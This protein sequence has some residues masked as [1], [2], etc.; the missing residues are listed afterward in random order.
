MQISPQNLEHCCVTK[1]KSPESIERKGE[2]G[3]KGG[4][5]AK[6]SNICDVT[7]SG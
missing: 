7:P 6:I 4:N 3:N 2:T 5:Y 1:E